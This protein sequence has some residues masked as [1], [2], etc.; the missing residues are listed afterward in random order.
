MFMGPGMP[1]SFAGGKAIPREVV[2][3]GWLANS[4]VNPSMLM[5]VCQHALALPC[6]CHKVLI[7]YFSKGFASCKLKACVWRTCI[8]GWLMPTPWRLFRSRGG[9]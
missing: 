6:G 7:L 4:Q 2:D 9:W 8:H 5:L 3:A 1:L